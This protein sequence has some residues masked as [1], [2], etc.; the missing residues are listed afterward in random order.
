MM[1][2]GN[3]L[4]DLCKSP[5]QMHRNASKPHSP[6]IPLWRSASTTASASL[7][8]RLRVTTLI[9]GLKPLGPATLARGNLSDA[10]VAGSRRPEE[11]WIADAREAED[12]DAGGGAAGVRPVAVEPEGWPCV[13]GEVILCSPDP[14]PVARLSL[15]VPGRDSS[16]SAPMVL[17]KVGTLLADARGCSG[18]APC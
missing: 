1:A 14:S 18:G 6:S 8:G 11:L 5:R 10:L 16:M 9:A 13:P 15:R 7:P 12:G 17:F 2:I 4:D 3:R